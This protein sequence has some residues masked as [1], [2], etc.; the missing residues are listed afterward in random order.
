MPGDCNPINPADMAPKITHF[1]KN[2][3]VAVLNIFPQA[4]QKATLFPKCNGAF[5]SAL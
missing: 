5:G 4:K 3:T 1:K 2:W